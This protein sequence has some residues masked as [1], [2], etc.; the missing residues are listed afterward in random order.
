MCVFMGFKN[1]DTGGQRI[2]DNLQPDWISLIGAVSC[3]VLHCSR[4]KIVVYNQNNK[5]NNDTSFQLFCHLLY[6]VLCCFEMSMWIENVFKLLA[7]RL[8]PVWCW[9]Q[10]SSLIRGIVLILC[11]FLKIYQT[12]INT[13]TKT[14][15]NPPQDCFGVF[16]IEASEIY[17]SYWVF[18]PWILQMKRSGHQYLQWRSWLECEN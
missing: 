4:N 2:S 10:R 11:S 16:L 7:G 15:Q 17:S 13:N 8:N 5:T 6:A 14:K 12:K 18:S 9:G 1:W 3:R